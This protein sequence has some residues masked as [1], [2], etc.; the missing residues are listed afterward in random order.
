VK[1]TLFNT[2]LTGVKYSGDKSVIG[3]FGNLEGVFDQV[4]NETWRVSMDAPC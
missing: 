2:T 1:Q 3:G 4:E